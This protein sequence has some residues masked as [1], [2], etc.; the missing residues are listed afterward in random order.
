MFVTW[1][2][3]GT[4]PSGRAFPTALSSGRQFVAMDHLLDQ[5]RFGPAHL[6]HP[7][8]AQM[9]VD[10]IG[11]PD[12]AWEVHSYVVM[13]NH[14]HLLLTPAIALHEAMRRIKGRSA[15]RA[16]LILG[17]TGRE[18]WQK[19]R[20][21]RPLG[22]GS[23]RVWAHSRVYRTESRSGGAGG[24]SRGLSLVERGSPAAR[25]KPHASQSQPH[26]ARISSQK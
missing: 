7:E 22:P 19:E 4:L 12:G 18:F 17:L 20:K 2:L 16:N 14:V 11:D 25:L 15:R 8:V 5:A 6:K 13:P 1:R 9:L 3:A 10:T 26:I 21:L 23:R 24:E